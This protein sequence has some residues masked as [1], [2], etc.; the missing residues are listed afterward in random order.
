[1][2]VVNSKLMEKKEYTPQDLKHLQNILL[3]ILKDFIEFCDKY[4]I[5]YFVDGGTALGCVRHKGFI[6]WDDDI[7]VLMFRDQY[8]KFLKYRH[9]F[10]D[11]YDIL[12]MEDYEKYCRVFTKISLKGT[13]TGEF[14]DKNTDFTYGISIDVFPF[15]NIP[16]PGLKR[17]LFIFHFEIFRKILFL[18]EVTNCDIYVSKNKERI[19]H[20][21]RFIF[22]ILHINNNTIK[23][24]GKKLINKSKKIDSDYV[25]SLGTPY[26]L[27]SFD[28]SIYSSTIKSKFESIEVNLPQNYDKY[29]KINYGDDYMELPPIEKR[30]NHKHEGFDFVE[31]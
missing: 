30:T 7:D 26:Y 27:Y 9:E 19:G 2:M 3:M 4:Q 10:D 29:F 8:K 21:I 12:T 5:D 28:K 23:K 14:F 6:P 24:L 31:Y 15:D 25:C 18:Y 17:K 13:K 11:K 16:N 1:M 20:I 22:K